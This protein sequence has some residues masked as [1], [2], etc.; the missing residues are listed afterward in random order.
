MVAISNPWTL[1]VAIVVGLVLLFLASIKIHKFISYLKRNGLR[2]I[3]AVLIVIGGLF[4]A[5][6][7]LQ[8]KYP[9]WVFIHSELDNDWAVKLAIGLVAVGALAI[10]LDWVIQKFRKKELM[11]QEE[12]RRDYITRVRK[13]I[14]IEKAEE[15]ALKHTKKKLKRGDIEIVASEKEF[16]T[17]MI[18]LKD[19][20]GQKYKAVLDIEGEVQD[21]ETVDALPSYLSG[22]F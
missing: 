15:I 11:G 2:G 21:W 3:G 14:T 16:K 6:V 18:Y 1:A 8:Q 22:P 19:G 9:E 12:E 5:L 17:W 10:V 20:K 13:G 7:L 4:A